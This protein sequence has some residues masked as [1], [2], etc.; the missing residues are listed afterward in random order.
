M[1][2]LFLLLVEDDSDRE[3]IERIYK[4]YIND[5]YKL[6]LKIT[7]NE[8]CARESISDA[9]LSI[10]ENVKILKTDNEI[11]L[12]AYI[13]KILKNKCYDR[14]KSDSDILSFEEI[15]DISFDEDFEK[16]LAEKEEAEII[17]KIIMK[18]PEKCRYALYFRYNEN[19]SISHIASLFDISEKTARKI[20]KEGVQYI[21]A[22]LH[23]V[24]KNGST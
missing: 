23:K 24:E 4:K 21:I 1:L 7:G 3:K 9:F 6:A 20:I 18:L 11:S 17:L 2:S 16:E 19:Y 14:I 5:M 8:R 22:T 13:L 15:E 12:R 10:I